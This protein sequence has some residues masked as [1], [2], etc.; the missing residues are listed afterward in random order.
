MGYSHFQE[1]KWV[2]LTFRNSLEDE[3]M[4]WIEIEKEELFR[5]SHLPPGFLIRV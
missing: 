3:R 1:R 2:T 4:R 5:V